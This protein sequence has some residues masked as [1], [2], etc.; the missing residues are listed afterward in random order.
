MFVAKGLNIYSG[1]IL[2]IVSRVSTLDFVVG[3]KGGVDA[4]FHSCSLLFSF[5][6]DQ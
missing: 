4:S 6:V 5:L 1:W 3:S 2:D